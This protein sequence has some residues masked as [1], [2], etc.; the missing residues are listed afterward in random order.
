VHI[1]SYA[2]LHMGNWVSLLKQGVDQMAS[3]GCFNPT[4]SVSS[5]LDNRDKP[6]SV[7]FDKHNL[8]SLSEMHG[9][10]GGS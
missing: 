3:S 9:D 7:I 10:E 8:L 6:S 2:Q 5:S 4:H 1:G